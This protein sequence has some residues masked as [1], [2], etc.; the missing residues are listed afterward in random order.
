MKYY[1]LTYLVSPELS[2]PEVKNTQQK[3][4]SF[5]QDKG[6]ILDSPVVPEKIDLSYPIKKNLQ[7]FLVSLSFYLKPEDMDDLEKK[8]KSESNIL[9]FL[10]YTKKKL[11][12]IKT[13]KKRSEKKPKQKAELK[14]IEQKLEE[15]LGK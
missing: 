6:G 10:I 2:E 12:E 11:K 7:A 15:I 4:H 14:D 3:L 5:I 1:E 9:R 8:I 13:S